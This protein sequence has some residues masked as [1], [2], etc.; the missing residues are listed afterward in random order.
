MNKLFTQKHPDGIEIV[1]DARTDGHQW[2][3][4]MKIEGVLKGGQK[5]SVSGSCDHRGWH[6]SAAIDGDET[7]LV[8]P[9]NWNGKP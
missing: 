4:Y 3:D 6:Y 2:I 7:D 5:F 8:N 9:K 1:N